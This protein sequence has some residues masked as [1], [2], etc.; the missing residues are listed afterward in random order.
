M[1]HGSRNCPEPQRERVVRH[2]IDWSHHPEMESEEAWKLL[3]K[4]D[5]E[6]DL[7]DIKEAFEI[8]AKNTSDATFQTIEQRLRAEN[9]N[10]RLVCLMKE[11]P[12]NKTNVDLQM[13]ADKTYVVGFQL[14]KKSRRTKMNEGMLADSYE[15]NFERLGD[16]GFTVTSN[17]PVCYNVRT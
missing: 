10:T 8:F 11:I 12:K 5:S 13:G 3:K 6:R 9:M 16:C 15:G 7:D 4:A 14:S 2:L 17:V 1:G